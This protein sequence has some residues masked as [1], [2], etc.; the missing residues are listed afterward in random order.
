MTVNDDSS[1]TTVNDDTSLTIVNDILK[2]KYTF[3]S[4]NI[5]VIC[6]DK[7]KHS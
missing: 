7:K 2:R 5:Q 4:E 6:F 1:L 3:W